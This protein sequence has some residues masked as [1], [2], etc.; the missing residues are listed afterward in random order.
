MKIRSTIHTYKKQ[1]KISFVE[2]AAVLRCYSI[3]F[4]LPIRNKQFNTTNA[5]QFNK[6][7]WQWEFHSIFSWII[8]TCTNSQY[9]TWCLCKK[10]KR[11]KNWIKKTYLFNVVLLLLLFRSHTFVRQIARVFFIQ[12]FVSSSFFFEFLF[13][14]RPLFSTN[15]LLLSQIHAYY[16]CFMCLQPKFESTKRKKKNEKIQL[17]YLS[18][19]E[20]TTKGDGYWH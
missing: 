19:W 16:V 9:F 4:L 13:Q 6:S 17:S 20:R 8:F 12:N 15:I 7:I 2:Y 5:E 1:N 10:K 14:L 3:L 18:R 11:R